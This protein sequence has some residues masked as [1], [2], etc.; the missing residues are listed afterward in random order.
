MKWKKSSRSLQT[1]EPEPKHRK[2][3]VCILT[4]SSCVEVFCWV[5]LRHLELSPR[6]FL[7]RLPRT[8]NSL[9]G[10]AGMRGLHLTAF[11]FL[12]KVV[13]NMFSDTKQIRSVKCRDDT[14]QWVL[15]VTN[16]WLHIGKNE[17]TTKSV[18]THPSRCIKHTQTSVLV[19]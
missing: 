15:A 5:G 14:T 11:S 18:T 16:I 6:L 19:G 9:F 3:E 8:H 12:L 13:K 7:I 4:T 17:R 2:R 10:E 1:Q